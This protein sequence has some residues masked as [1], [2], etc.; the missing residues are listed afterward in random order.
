MSQLPQPAVRRARLDDLPDIE[1]LLKACAL[2]TDGVAQVLRTTPE[3]FLVAH[4]ASHAL[5]A[6]AGVEGHGVHGLL[7]SVAVHPNARTRGVGAALVEQLV[8][9]ADASGRTALFLLTTTAEDYFPRFGFARTERAHVPGD[10]AGTV[11][12]AGAC[13]ASA[14]V[15]VRYASPAA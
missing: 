14:V 7:R 1:A 12:F 11:E 10:I 4:D 15:M 5:I 8:A 3:Q 6:V 2:P 9:E 13:P